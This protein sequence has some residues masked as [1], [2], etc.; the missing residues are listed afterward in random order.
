MPAQIYGKVVNERTLI[1][2]RPIKAGEKEIIVKLKIEPIVRTK[3]VV[4]E[5]IVLE[6]SEMDMEELI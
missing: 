3:I 4:P 5:D 6:I 2:N 1:L